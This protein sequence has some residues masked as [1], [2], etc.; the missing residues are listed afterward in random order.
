LYARW[1]IRL[2]YGPFEATVA[3]GETPHLWIGS[4]EQSVMF[5]DHVPEEI[6]GTCVSPFEIFLC[7][8]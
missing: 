6:E 7:D 3:S 2:G 5:Y 1:Q 4:C 8:E